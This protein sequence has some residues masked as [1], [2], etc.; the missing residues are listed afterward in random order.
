M[1][2]EYYAM[3]YEFDYEECDKDTCPHCSAGCDYCLMLDR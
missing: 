3:Y 1:N 2:E